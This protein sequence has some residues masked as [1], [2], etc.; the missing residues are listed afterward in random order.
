MDTTPDEFEPGGGVVK[1]TPTRGSEAQAEIPLVAKGKCWR[2][3]QEGHSGRAQAHIRKVS[4][5]AFNSVCQQCDVIGHFNSVSKRGDKKTKSRS[6]G[7][8]NPF[9]DLN[10]G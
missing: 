10:I 8:R 1:M 2:C 3:N 6:E 7:A 9:R 4:C 5:A